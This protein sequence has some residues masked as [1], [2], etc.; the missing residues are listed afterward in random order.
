MFDEKEL[1]KKGK[2]LAKI[3]RHDTEG[4]SIDD[5]GFIKTIDVLNH[6]KIESDFLDEI[7]SKN[8]K[9]RFEF[10]SDKSAIRARQGHSLENVEIDFKRVPTEE[11]PQILY[12]GT[13]KEC[14]KKILEVG[15]H[16][17][18]RNFAHLSKDEETAIQVG[19][20]KKGELAIL[21]VYIR[22]YLKKNLHAELFLSSNGVYLIK[23]VSPEYIVM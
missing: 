13:N 6:L 22:S 19:K 23:V 16:K 9:N 8:N 12:H 15:L 1:V 11:A 5:S 14:A 17:M 10:N 4:L 7:V 21:K 18:S 2:H 3:L 20:R